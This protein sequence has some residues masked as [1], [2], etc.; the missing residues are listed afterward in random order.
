M[1]DKNVMDS[2]VRELK[3]AG[4]KNHAIPLG[5]TVKVSVCLIYDFFASGLREVWIQE[6][7]SKCQNFVAIFWEN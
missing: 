7:G 3:K 6:N 1:L 4:M 5:V 2:M